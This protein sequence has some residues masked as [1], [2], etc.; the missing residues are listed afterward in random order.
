[1]RHTFFA[2]CGPGIEPVLHAECKALRLAK[3]ERQVGGVRFEG[4]MADARRA[5]LQLRTAVRVRRWLLRFPCPDGDALYRGVSGLDWSAFVHPEGT[6]VVDALSSDS[7]LTHTQ[8]VEQRAKDAIVDQMRARTGARPSVDKSNPDLRVHV[9]LFRD[10]A[11]VAVDCGGASL[12]KRGWRVHQGRAPLAETYAAALVL[13]SGWNQRA[14]LLDPFC[15]SGT[16]LIEAGLLAGGVAPGL[17]RERFGF[18]SWSDH[19]A[20]AWEREC[21]AA[22]AAIAHPK[23]LRLIG[24]DHDPERVEEAREN[25]A[26]AGLDERIE[27]E[28]GDARDMEL[29][30]GW[31]AWLV[32]NAPYGARVGEGDEIEGVLESLGERLRSEAEGYHVAALLGEKRHEGRL[33]LRGA[34]RTMLRNGSLR[35]RLY[36]AQV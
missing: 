24:R 17:F 32:T 31:N 9:H 2:T 12:H 27:F 25:A 6:L 22:R 19:D 21:A 14:P 34:Q 13:M 8:F 7:A 28:V 29:K 33:G 15:G 20:R 36:Q 1:M 3:T 10:R 26:S 23:K 16:I 35:V 4:S 11:T 5:C 18:E 30:P